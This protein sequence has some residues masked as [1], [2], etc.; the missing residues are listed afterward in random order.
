MIILHQKFDFKNNFQELK[1]CLL[2]I[3]LCPTWEDVYKSF[4]FKQIGFMQDKTYFV[5]FGPL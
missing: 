1:T 2:A 4:H 3:L 5:L